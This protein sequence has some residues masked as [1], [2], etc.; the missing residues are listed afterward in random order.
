MTE[1]DS[2]ERPV[3][4]RHAEPDDYEAL[5]QIMSGPRA[6]AGTLQLPLQPAEI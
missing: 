6:V 3:I 2:K 1:E 5:H 4:V